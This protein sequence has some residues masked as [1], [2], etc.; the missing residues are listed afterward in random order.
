MNGSLGCLFSLFVA[1]GS[2]GGI[3]YLLSLLAGLFD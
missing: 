3:L 2:V 1:L